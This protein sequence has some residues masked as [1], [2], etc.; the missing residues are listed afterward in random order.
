MKFRYG[1]LMIFAAAIRLASSQALAAVVVAPV[2]LSPGL[3]VSPLP[4]GFSS[5]DG[6]PSNKLYDQTQAFSFS[7]G[8]LAET[9][10][11]RVIQYSDAPSPV[12][13]GLYFDY[14]IQLLSGDITSFAVS[15]YSGFGTSVKVCG[16]AGCGGS[17]A[18]GL[19]PTS[20]TRTTDGDRI[21][22]N[23]GT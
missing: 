8:S 12:H 9:L 20:A 10:H 1:A 19:A 6:I 4:N 15:G 11:D 3:T 2:D 21:T 16:I 17:G 18:N 7:G 23:F 22:F 5:G 13:P 14:E